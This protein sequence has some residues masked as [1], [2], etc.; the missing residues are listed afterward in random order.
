MGFFRSKLVGIIFFFGL[1]IKFFKLLSKTMRF[2]R[3]KSVR[4][5][6]FSKKKQK[7]F[8]KKNC[9]TDDMM[10]VLRTC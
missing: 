3:S 5:Q 10:L 9:L 1:K 2:F 7:K 6:F 8:Q 4:I